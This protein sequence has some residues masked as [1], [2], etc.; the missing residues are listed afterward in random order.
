MLGGPVWYEY[1]DKDYPNHWMDA[2]DF[3]FPGTLNPMSRLSRE[4]NSLKPDDDM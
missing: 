3:Y 4:L 1:V 2:S